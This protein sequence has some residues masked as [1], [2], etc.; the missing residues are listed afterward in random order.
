MSGETTPVTTRMDEVKYFAKSHK[1]E[2]ALFA[3]ITT[4][5]LLRR[6]YKIR[7]ENALEMD[8]KSWEMLEIGYAPV[9]RLKDMD[10]A[11]MKTYVPTA[12]EIAQAAIDK[13]VLMAEYAKQFDGEAVKAA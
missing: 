13:A 8:K 6:H 11:V 9:F 5:F 1:K 2:L 3:A 7:L 4:C 10:V 12:E